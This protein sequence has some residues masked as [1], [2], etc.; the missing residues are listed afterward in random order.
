MVKDYKT[1][2]VKTKLGL[3]FAVRESLYTKGSY[4]RQIKEI[5]CYGS[6]LIAPF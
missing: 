6:E 1:I 2:E 3:Q 4:K 5:L